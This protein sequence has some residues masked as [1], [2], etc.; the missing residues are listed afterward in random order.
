MTWLPTDNGLWGGEPDSP[1]VAA[2]HL[3]VRDLVRRRLAESGLGWDAFVAGPIDLLITKADLVAIDAAVLATGHRYAFSATISATERPDAYQGLASLEGGFSHP[4]APSAPP[5][6]QGRALCG[7]G[8]N[9]VQG[10]HD[11]E[12]IARYVRSAAQVIA[13]M[14]QGVPDGSIAIIDD[15]GGTLTAPILD[16]FTGLVCAGGT[17]RSHLGILAREHGIPCL[18]NAKLSGIADGDRVRLETSAPART[19][20]SYL[21]GTE[22]PARIWKLA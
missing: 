13:L 10:S 12:G 2:V 22:M 19:A 20:D 17:V 3:S 1:L 4:D 7:V 8:D 21:S 6:S 18:M 9:V 14:E 5:D 11:I 15:S 16:R